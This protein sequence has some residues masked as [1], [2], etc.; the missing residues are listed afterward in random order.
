VPFFIVNGKFTL[1]GA[2]PPDTFL[3]AFRQAK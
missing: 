1:S 3:E 2:Q